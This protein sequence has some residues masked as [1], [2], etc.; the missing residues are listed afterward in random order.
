MCESLQEAYGVALGAFLRDPENSD[1]LKE[2]LKA[3]RA[4]E[5][6]LWNIH[7]IEGTSRSKTA[8]EIK[9]IVDCI[10]AG[11]SPEECIM[12]IY[13]LPKIPLPFPSPCGMRSIEVRTQIFD[14]PEKAMIFSDKLDEAFK[15]TGVKL[16]NDETYSCLVCIVKK[17][18]YIS[19]VLVSTST[20]PHTQSKPPVNY[21][22]EPTIMKQVMNTIERDKIKW[23]GRL[24]KVGAENA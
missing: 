10:L 4:Y 16:E 22:M 3:K 2:Y 21:I 15:A 6:C 5:R 1:L 20:L 9:E 23:G 18:K 7:R 17:P 13:R 8:M 12:G 11:E 14:D 19:E 24:G